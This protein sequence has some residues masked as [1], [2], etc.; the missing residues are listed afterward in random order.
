MTLEDLIRALS[1][2][3]PRGPVRRERDTRPMQQA[4]TRYPGQAGAAGA[5][6][7]QDAIPAWVGRANAQRPAPAPSQG[8]SMPLPR[9]SE[10]PARLAMLEQ[11]RREQAPQPMDR[12]DVGGA[13]A[14]FE[15]QRR[16]AMQYGVD[17]MM[18]GD[19][20]PQQM[21]T[22]QRDGGMQQQGPELD[23]PS[24]ASGE[25]GIPFSALRGSGHGAQDFAGY[26][27]GQRANN[28]LVDQLAVG[29]RG[30]PALPPDIAP[31]RQNMQ[32]T[33]GALRA[34]GPV[35]GPGGSAMP[36]DDLE[37]QFRA[38]QLRAAWRRRQGR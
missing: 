5:L 20:W 34:L 1:G 4:P 17:S 9:E 7:R 13:F 16:G 6:R 30:G 31:S 26:V 12:V 32:A 15:A 3:N 24:V 8:P 18:R 19:G 36:E 10:L 14:D 35:Q 25:G 28:P 37:A 38:A 33:P 21:P 22:F 27:E 11:L 29:G 23:R 2:D